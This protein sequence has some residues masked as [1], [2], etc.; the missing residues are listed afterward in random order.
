MLHDV[1]RCLIQIQDFIVVT[2]I[3]QYV[4]GYIRPL[5]I[6]LKSVW[7]LS[8]TLQKARDIW[9]AFSG[10]ISA[11][12]DAKFYDLY[13]SFRRKWKWR[14]ADKAKKYKDKEQAPQSNI[15]RSLSR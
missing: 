14:L 5:S 15:R 1:S 8:E 10:H 11:D 12:S 4:L 9:F 3:L 6:L 13:E 7:W 2:V